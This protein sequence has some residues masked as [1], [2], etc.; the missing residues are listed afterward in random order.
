MSPWCSESGVVA[1]YMEGLRRLL[2]HGV[3]AAQLGVGMVDTFLCEPGSLGQLSKKVLRR[4]SG[5][6]AGQ[7]RPH[8]DVL[9][10]PLPSNVRDAVYDHDHL[11]AAALQTMVMCSI[12]RRLHSLPH[13]VIQLV[14]QTG[15]FAD[16]PCPQLWLS[17]WPLCGHPLLPP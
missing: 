10:L 8:R 9:P 12:S 11:I 17:D 7:P 13:R 5:K 3:T 4:S 14:G 16:T 6:G 1:E 15:R 2:I